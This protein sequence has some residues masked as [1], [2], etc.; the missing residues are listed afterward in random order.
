M[1]SLKQDVRGAI[2]SHEPLVLKPSDGKQGALIPQLRENVGHDSPSP[3]SGAGFPLQFHPNCL[4]KGSQPGGMFI[5][6][7]ARP[8]FRV[9]DVPGRAIKFVKGHVQQS[10]N[11]SVVTEAKPGKMCHR[12]P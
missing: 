6:H 1:W 11:T 3:G 8:S 5:E 12:S 2:D 4:L 10:D 9:N 7:C